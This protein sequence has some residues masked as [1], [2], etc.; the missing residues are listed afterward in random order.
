[1]DKLTNIQID[2]DK[3]TFKI[4]TEVDLS[5]YSKEVYI[6]EVWN[7]KNILEDSPIHNI[8]FSENITVDSENN[9]TVTNDDILELDWNMKYVTLRCFTEQEEIHFHGIYYNPS[10]VYMAEIRKLH[11][12]CSTCLDD[13]TMQNIMLVVFKRQLLEYALASDYYRD[14]LQLYVDICRLLEISIKPKCAAS[15]CCNNAILT[16]KGDCFN[17]ENDKCLHLEKERNSATLFSGICYS[18]S[19]NTCST[20]NCSMVIVNYKIN[21]YDTKM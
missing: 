16:Q 5:S 7:L 11:T 6:D 19:N 14:A 20:G 13:Q 17:T 15:T 12:H 4:E 10:I 3:L 2:G 21:R 1:M 9:V 8:S 18:C